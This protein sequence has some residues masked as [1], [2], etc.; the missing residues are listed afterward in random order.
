[1]SEESTE[2]DPKNKVV[3]YV[4]KETREV[5][6]YINVSLEEARRRVLEHEDV[7][8]LALWSENET[9]FHDTFTVFDTRSIFE[10]VNQAI[11]V[12]QLDE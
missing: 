8:D 9:T 12:M 4:E 5:I 10:G 6:A 11:N 7:S 2:F 1:M 3:V